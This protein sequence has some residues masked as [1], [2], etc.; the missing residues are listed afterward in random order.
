MI[1]LPDDRDRPGLRGGRREQREQR[2][3]Q[4]AP[5]HVRLRLSF[6]RAAGDPDVGQLA[7]LDRVGEGPPGGLGGGDRDRQL[8]PRPQRARAGSRGRRAGSAPG[9]AARSASARAATGSRCPVQRNTTRA[10]ARRV[11]H[12][13]EPQLRAPAV[14]R[15]VVEHQRPQQRERLRARVAVLVDGVALD[16]ERARPDR[17][18]GVVA[19]GGDREAVG[20]AVE[21]DVVAAVAVLVDAVL[22]RL[23]RRPGRSP[24]WRR[25]SRRRS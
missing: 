20:V 22:E 18:V 11:A 7:V 12:L 24:G 14:D 13:Q 10:P 4:D 17:A 21:V 15:P 9:R 8:R 25:C 19:V 6:G 23:A 5:Q 2:E 3:D 16:L 1:V